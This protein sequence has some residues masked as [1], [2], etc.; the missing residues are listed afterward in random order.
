MEE[1]KFL[2]LKEAAQY[3]RLNERTMKNILIRNKENLA[4][5]KI[6]GK[7]L[8]DKK[9]LTNLLNSNLFVY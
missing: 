9:V 7:Y 2:T 5:Q 1:Q 6:G 3:L 4:Y 8:I